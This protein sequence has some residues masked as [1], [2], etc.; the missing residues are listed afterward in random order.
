LNARVLVV[1]DDPVF[2]EAFGAAIGQAPDLTLIGQAGDCASAL[3][4]LAQQPDV[5]LVDLGLPD[6]SGIELIREA[7]HRLPRAEIMV[8]T[9][10]GDEKSVMDSIAAG[11]S[12]YL[13]KDERAEGIVARIRELLAG[14]SPIS[15]VIAR[16]LLNRL[17]RSPRPHAAADEASL[18]EQ[19]TRVLDFAARG[20]SYDEIAG[21]MGVSKHSVQTYVKRAYRKLHVHTKV[22]ALAEARRLRLLPQ[23]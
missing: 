14:G 11:A 15:P 8:V 22:E 4:L 16:Q 19:E 1:E 10:F 9:V 3:A 13:L 17:P 2:R 21:L 23:T 5:L 7:M 12:G 20:F 18:S 6:G